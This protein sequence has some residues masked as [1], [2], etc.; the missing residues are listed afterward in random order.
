[1]FWSTVPVPR[2]R[3]KSFTRTHLRLTTHMGW[4][5][6]VGSWNQQVSLAQEP[7]K[8]DYV[9]QKRPI[10]SR[11]LLIVATP[12]T[13]THT[14]TQTHAHKHAEKR[15]SVLWT[16][17]SVPRMRPRQPCHTYIHYVTHTSTLS[18]IHPPCHTHIRIVTHTSTLSHIHPPCHSYM[19]HVTHIR[20]YCPRYKYM[21]TYIRVP[22][23]RQPVCPNSFH[24]WNSP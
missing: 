11:S 10:N 2:C 8:T 15:H 16:V 6:F 3:H 14:R 20:I 22:T 13:H 18:H 17:K 9:L 5:R 7:Y 24:T 4:L 23:V 21:Q 1:M 19:G 12:H